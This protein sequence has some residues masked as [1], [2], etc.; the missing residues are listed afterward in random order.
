MP[1]EPQGGRLNTLT[2]RGPVVF[3]GSKILSF[4]GVIQMQGILSGWQLIPGIFA[5]IQVH[6]FLLLNTVLLKIMTIL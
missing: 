2:D 5:R 4:L 1:T 3:L 6:V